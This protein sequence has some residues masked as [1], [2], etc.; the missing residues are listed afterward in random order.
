MS[1]KPY[2]QLLGN[3]VYVHVP[4]RKTSK[5]EVDANTKEALQREM[6]KKMSKLKVYDVGDLVTAFKAGDEVLVDPSKLKDAHLIPLSDDQEVLLLSPF[7]VI[8][9]W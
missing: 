7:D 3:R 9:V 2:K 6:L 1:K 4:E 5:L 8:H